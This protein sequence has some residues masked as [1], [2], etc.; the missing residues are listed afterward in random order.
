MQIYTPGC[1]QDGTC[2]TRGIVNVTGTFASGTESATSLPTQIFQTNDFDKYDEIYSGFVDSNTNSFRP[3]VTLT[4]SA[5]QNGNITLVAQRVRFQ[6][7]NSTGGLNGL[8]EYNSS[9]ATVD[10]DFSNSIFDQAGM[11]LNTGAVVNSLAVIGSTTF[12]AGNFSGDGIEN[13]FSVSTGNATSL[14]GGGLDAEIFSTYVDG[15][16]LYV[17]GNFSKTTNNSV[18]GLSNLAAFD[19]NKQTWQPLGAGVNGRVLT[20]VPLLLNISNGQPETCIT[21]N[22]NFNQILASNLGDPIAVEGLAVWVP[23]QNNWLQNLNLQTMAI[24]GQLSAATNVSGSSPLLAGTISSQGMAINDAV[25]LS[26]S[27]GSLSLDSLGLQIQPQQSGFS[28]KKRAVAGQN[29]FGVVTGLFYNNGGLDLTILGGHF[30]ANAA[31]GSTINNIAFVNNT[32]NGKGV[33]SIGSGVDP[34]SSF[35][36]LATQDTTL[37]A[38]GTVTGQVN[39][40]TVDGLILYDL[41]SNAFSSPQPPALA[42]DSVL[43]NAISVRPSSTE[44]YVGG[45][46]DAAGSLG[47]PSICVFNNQQWNRPGSGLAGNV[48]TLLWQN[49]DQLLVG[50]NLTVS[51]NATSLA[52]YDAKTGQWAVVNGANTG[53]PGPV[54]ALAPSIADRSQYWVAGKSLNNSAFLIKYD[55]ANFQPVSEDLGNETTILGLSM[56]DLSVNHAANNL[57]DPTMTLLITGQLNLPSFGNA[58]AALFNGTTFSPFIL[59]TSGNGP[60]SLSQI[61][62][63]KTVVFA[64]SGKSNLSTDENER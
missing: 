3:T 9:Q 16:V 53:I 34:D 19:T 40:A 52:T 28:N 5:N 58:S 26:N 38:G 44:V 33:S 4:P 54:T 62:T 41:A 32:D 12:V 45:S 23:S 46:F 51:S 8:F 37:Y 42:G 2:T 55:G 25:A 47:C 6:L 18:A 1:K 30:A 15:T 21:L 17:G 60:G 13:I 50:G 36:A 57:V 29:S 59:S 35:L 43:V 22:G 10:S 63:E 31:D 11:T 48:S 49:N 20:I 61:F 39:G 14:P 24:S 64:T 7:L 56:L 27:G